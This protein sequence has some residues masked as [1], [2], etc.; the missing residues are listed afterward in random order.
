MI[1]GVV[2]DMDGTLLNTEVV[3][4]RSWLQ[5]ASE[6][7]IPL[8]EELCTHMTGRRSRD[9]DAHL[10]AAL[11]PTT[12]IPGL[13]ALARKFYHEELDRHMPVKPGALENLQFLQALGIPQAVATSTA[14]DTACKKLANADMKQFFEHVV[15]GDQVQE[16]KPAPEIFHKAGSLIKVP[17]NRLIVVED[18]GPGIQGAAAAQTTP[19]LVPDLVQY[20]PEITSLAHRIFLNLWEL[21]EFF[22]ELFV[23]K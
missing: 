11:G 19:I 13:R 2:W 4:R 9:V 5:A 16:G 3:A 23:K 1:E 20:G 15:G 22:R 21:L 18:S 8:T 17:S 12:D 6:L 10:A 7:Q 14:H